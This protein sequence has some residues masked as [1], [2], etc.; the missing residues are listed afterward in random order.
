MEG[1]T[2]DGTPLARSQSGI[3]TP[4]RHRARPFALDQTLSP[5]TPIV[6]GLNLKRFRAPLCARNFG[7]E[8]Q[9]E[10]RACALS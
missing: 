3:S 10:D 1:L 9:K 6:T 2:S 8:N 4:L 7:R 5:W